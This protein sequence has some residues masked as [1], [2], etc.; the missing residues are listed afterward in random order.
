MPPAQARIRELKLKDEDELQSYF[1]RRMDQFL[2]GKGRRL[3]GWDEIL[4]GGLAP[5]ATVMSWRG[6]KGGIAAAQSGHDVVM[7][8]RSS[9][10]STTTSRRIPPSPSAPAAASRSNAPTPTTP[11][12]EGFTAEQARRVLGTQ[13]QLW[14]EAIADPHQMEFMA[15]PRLAALAEVAWTPLAKKDYTDFTTRLKDQQQRWT[16]MGV[17]FRP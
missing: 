8:P 1:I 15:F 11:F 5:G 10:T 7:T 2:T 6:I 4:E 9:L 13:G 17:N 3:I 12:P 16:L 14:T